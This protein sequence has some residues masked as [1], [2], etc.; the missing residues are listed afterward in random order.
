M[1]ATTKVS[2]AVAQ[3]ASGAAASFTT[4]YAG[5]HYLGL[6]VTATTVPNV[7]GPP[8][9]GFGAGPAT[10]APA[11][12]GSSSSGLTTPPAFPFTAAA[13]VASTVPMYAAVAA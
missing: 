7:Y 13:V 1:P 2:Y 3:T 9:Q 10:D 11:F 5:L 12:S 4:T 8:S 6:L